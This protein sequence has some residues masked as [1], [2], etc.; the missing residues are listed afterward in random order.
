[1][2]AVDYDSKTKAVP[3]F[4]DVK[5]PTN[6]KRH[7]YGIAVKGSSEYKEKVAKMS[8]Q[9]ERIKTHEIPRL[10]TNIRPC[11]C[12]TDTTYFLQYC[13]YCLEYAD[14]DELRWLLPRKPKKKCRDMPC[15]SIVKGL[16]WPRQVT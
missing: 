11:G 13:C 6:G 12:T 7:L 16:G 10:E 1:M 5:K 3:K 14:I 8:A 2:D 15:S 9:R 4:R